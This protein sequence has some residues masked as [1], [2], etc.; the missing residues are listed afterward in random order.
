M[1]TAKKPAPELAWLFSELPT[2]GE[3]LRFEF[4]PL[5]KTLA[6]LALNPANRTPWRS[7]SQRG[8]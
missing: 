2:D 5:A 7:G 4:E 1:T 6:E 8:S 3:E